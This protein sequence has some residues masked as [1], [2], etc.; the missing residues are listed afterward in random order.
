MRKIKAN[1]I[2]TILIYLFFCIYV[3]KSVPFFTEQKIVIIAKVSGFCFS[4]QK[5]SQWCV[6]LNA[7]QTAMARH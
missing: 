7:F 1:T 5:R 2:I 3:S 6:Q 4:A